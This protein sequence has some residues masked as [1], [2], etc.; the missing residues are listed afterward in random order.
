MAVDRPFAC[1]LLDEPVVLF[2]DPQG[3]SHALADR[4]PHCFVPLHKGDVRHGTAG[5]A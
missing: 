5:R 1:T 3:R 2:R 4:C